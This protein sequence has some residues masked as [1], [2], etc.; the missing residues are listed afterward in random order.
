MWYESIRNINK[1]A[2]FAKCRLREYEVAVDKYTN[3]GLEVDRINFVILEMSP[4]THID[5]SAVEA[6]KELYQE[7]KTRDIQ[8][9]ISNPN[10]DVHLTIARSGMVEL[11]GKEW[12]FVRVHDAVQVCLQYVQSSNLEDKHLSFTRRYGGSNNNSSSS[13]ALLKEPLLSVEK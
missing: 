2:F 8:L 1:L 9:A 6:L 13:N 7:Y 11:V 4:V 5:S 3:R 12:F 10:K